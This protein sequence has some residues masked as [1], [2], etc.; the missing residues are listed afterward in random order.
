[1]WQKYNCKGHEFSSIL[2]STL[3]SLFCFTVTLKSLNVPV[4]S[5]LLDWNSHRIQD[6]IQFSEAPKSKLPTEE[7]CPT[8]LA[9]AHT[10]RPKAEVHCVRTSFHMMA[11][12]NLHVSLPQPLPAK[13]QHRSLRY[14]SSDWVN[15]CKFLQLILVR[16]LFIHILLMWV[17]NWSPTENEG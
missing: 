11:D 6:P 8:P 3:I 5:M 2:L 9:V 4:P 17:A 7:R 12:T 13:C 15:L 1:M 16:E 14:F 10:S